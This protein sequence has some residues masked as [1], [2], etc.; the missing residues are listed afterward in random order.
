MEFE[1]TF[2]WGPQG[3]GDIKFN[4]T[5]DGTV[6]S[7]RIV[8]EDGTVY[9]IDA[10]NIDENVRQESLKSGYYSLSLDESRLTA[11]RPY[12]GMFPV[13]FAGF[14]RRGEED[15]LEPYL[16][17]ASIRTRV[18]KSGKKQRYPVPASLR[19]TSILQIYAG[20]MKGYSYLYWLPYIFEM[21][22]DGVTMAKSKNSRD[23]E[24]LAGFLKL[25]G[26][27][28]EDSNKTIPY[29]D[30]VLPYLEG[31]LTQLTD[32]HP[33]MTIVERGWPVRLENIPTGMSFEA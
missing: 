26:W 2:E 21:G 24:R 31:Q 32:G 9:P 16:K 25:T 19:F 29:S 23:L 8:A 20:P 33:F 30:N 27:D 1:Q 7:V 17:P 28:I 15:I 22:S 13:R 11:V 3:L 12:A 18:L 14:T 10:E 6:T 4:K 5:E